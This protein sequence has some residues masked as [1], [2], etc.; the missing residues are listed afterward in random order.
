MAVDAKVGRIKM[1]D[2]A[3]VRDVVVKMDRAVIKTPATLDMFRGIGGLSKLHEQ[4]L[5]PCLCVALSPIGGLMAWPK[6]MGANYVGGGGF[7]INFWVAVICR[8]RL[9]IR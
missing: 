7:T 2:V 8:W 6:L 3:E 5:L 4:L 9:T 1:M